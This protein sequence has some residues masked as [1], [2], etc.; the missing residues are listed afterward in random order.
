[1]PIEQ[2][3]R[4][5]PLGTRM[6]RRAGAA[7][8]EP[9]RYAN[10]NWSSCDWAYSAGRRTRL[11]LWCDRSGASGAARA[12]VLLFSGYQRDLGDWGLKVDEGE[13]SNLR[14][15]LRDLMNAGLQMLWREWCVVVDWI[16]VRA[17]EYSDTSRIRTP[18]VRK[19]YKLYTLYEIQILGVQLY[20][21][22]G[23]LYTRKLNE[24]SFWGTDPLGKITVFSRIEWLIPLYN[25]D[26][27][28]RETLV[29]MSTNDTS[30][31]LT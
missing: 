26:H 23:E 19:L 22:Y 8:R 14:S 5:S 11:S 6:V 25:K 9:G 29:G 21:H 1:M 2:R 31:I 18:I 3:H 24:Y 13:W 28:T 30:D 15:D 20:F 17:V 12:I 10:A 16:S 27:F 7:C 4:A